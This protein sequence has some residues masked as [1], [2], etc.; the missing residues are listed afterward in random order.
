MSAANAADSVV[1]AF[2]AAV[3]GA[4]VEVHRPGEFGVVGVR[5]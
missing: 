3:D 5:G 4:V 1:G 2:M